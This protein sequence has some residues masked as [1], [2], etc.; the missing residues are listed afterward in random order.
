MED[1]AVIP[2]SAGFLCVAPRV[3]VGLPPD[4][5]SRWRPCPSPSLRLRDHL[6]RGLSPRSFCAMPGTHVAVQRRR[7]SAAHCNRLLAGSLL[8]MFPVAHL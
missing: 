7:V 2:P 6:A 5:T 4:P 1:F 8:P 3:W